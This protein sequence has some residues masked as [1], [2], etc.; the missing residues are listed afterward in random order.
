MS[1]YDKNNNL[2]CPHDKATKLRKTKTKD[3]LYDYCG[4]AY[5]EG[6]LSTSE[7]SLFNQED[8]EKVYIIGPSNEEDKKF[9]INLG[10]VLQIIEN[11]PSEMIDADTKE[12][13]NSEKIYEIGE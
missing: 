6:M 1:N 4:C 5:P 10:S 13:K 11:N 8:I 2:F 12:E 9:K 3:K 7:V